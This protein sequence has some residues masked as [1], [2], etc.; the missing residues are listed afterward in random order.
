MWTSRALN[1]FM[2]RNMKINLWSIS[3]NV[4]DSPPAIFSGQSDSL[5]FSWKKAQKW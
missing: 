1:P 4:P 5:F 2:A 3:L